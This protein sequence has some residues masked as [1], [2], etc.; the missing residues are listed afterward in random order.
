LEA[1]RLGSQKAG[2]DEASELSSIQPFQPSS[3]FADTRNLTP[4]T[5]EIVLFRKLN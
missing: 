1:G 3:C 5:T 4:E 2:S